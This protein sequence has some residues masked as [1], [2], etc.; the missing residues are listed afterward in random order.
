M[1]V[2]LTITDSTLLAE[3]KQV[4]EVTNKIREIAETHH[5]TKRGGGLRVNSSNAAEKRAKS[6][7]I[8]FLQM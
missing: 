7:K 4:D 1:Q 5:T 6:R 2:R 8:L 3:L